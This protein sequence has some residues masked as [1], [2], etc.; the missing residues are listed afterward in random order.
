MPNEEIAQH[1][2]EWAEVTR[3]HFAI[4]GLDIQQDE[5]ELAPGVTLQ[6][7]RNHPSFQSLSE[8]LSDPMAIGLVQ[9]YVNKK[10]L[11]FELVIDTE[12]LEEKISVPELAD[13]IVT[14]IGVKTESDIICLTTCEVSWGSMDRLT[15]QKFK[16]RI[17]NA[18]YMP[19][20][21]RPMLVSDNDLAWIKENLRAI[22]DLNTDAK[23]ATA[24]KSF[25][26]QMHCAEPSLAVA[27]TWA[28]I[29]SLVGGKFQASYSLSLLAA[30]LLEPRGASCESRRKAI[31]SLYDRRSDIIHGRSLR[32]EQVTAHAMDARRLLSQLLSKLIELGRVYDDENIHTLATHLPQNPDDSQARPLT[33]PN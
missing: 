14:A 9:H 30:L 12:Y 24:F 25:S 33:T 5:F 21:Y 7:I 31:R 8:R 20:L 26:A 27:Q 16:T 23:F 29:E 6:R 32:L 2:D 13:L 28:G 11:R 1:E 4:V 15:N 18:T 17:E 10:S 3:W 22:L 19:N